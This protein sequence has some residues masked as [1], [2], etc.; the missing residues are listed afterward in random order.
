MLIL[1]AFI[2][3]ALAAPLPAPEA[4]DAT[5][6]MGP[7]LFAAEVPLSTAASKALSKRDHAAAVTALKGIDPTAFTGPQSS[8]LG[9]LKA[10]SL[11]RSNRA[12]EAQT[13]LGH[14]EASTTVPDGYRWLTIG[15]V[16]L[17]NGAL[18]KAAESFQRITP[19]EPI[20]DRAKL[21]LAA[22]HKKS[23][24]TK[25]ALELYAELAQR[26]D[27][28]D[29]G[30]IALWALASKRGLS[31]PS[32]VP[33]LRRLWVHYPLSSA[34]KSADSALKAHHG[35][36]RTEDY[37][38]RAVRLM[39][40]GAWSAVNGTVSPRIAQFPLTTTQGCEVQYAHG[41]SLFKRNQV[42]AASSV[43]SAVGK[44]CAT[45]A[46]EVGPKALY[47]AG[48][49]FERKKHWAQA[50]SVYQLIP[51]LYPE[52]SMAD[53][54]YALGGIA[55]V[56]AGQPAQA[57]GLWTKQA[58]TYPTGD[59]AGEGFWRLAWSAY[60]SGDTSKAIDWAERMER[61]VPLNVD[62]TH[63]MGARYW[64]ARWHLYPDV[65]HPE[66]LSPDA[67]AVTSGIDG[68]VSLIT[69]HPAGF[70]SLLAAARL[71][72]L[73]PESLAAIP[74]PS[75]ASAGETWTVRKTFFEH[76][77]TQRALNLAR[78]GLPQEAM[79]EFRTLGKN[80]TPS[81]IAIITQVQ[82]SYDPYVA[83]DRLH[84][85]LLHHPP[86][87]LG[88]DRDRVMLEAL[89]NHYF[90]TIELVTENYDF[91]PRIF[92]A[93]VREESSFNKDIRSWAGARGL[94]QLMPATGKQVAGWLGISVTK[95]KLHDPETNLK[96]GS[97]YL[98]YLFDHFDNNP[99][100]AVA[101]Y[102]AGEGNVGKW[103][104]RFGNIPT[105]EF[106][107]HIPFRE[108]RHYVKRVLGTYQAYRVI[109]GPDTH[110]PQWD[111]TN[112]R[113]VDP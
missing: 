57:R 2:N 1:A 88:P 22:A 28:A 35:T 4:N 108:T 27:P 17:A 49:S 93:L 102:N 44:K 36:I 73:A 39:E 76:P 41:R 37:A 47:I 40:L 69:D 14:I 19:D 45:L 82:A 113:V 24:A 110:P 81:E 6:L 58:D 95:S 107:E 50:A 20:A 64:S 75:A 10:W 74:A 48:K 33:W 18:H 31:N 96:I 51:V 84:R 92:H 89:P 26:D 104:K 111:H 83:H 71:A 72:E 32:A 61:E 65:Q 99:F 46:P 8:A 7:A 59:M 55:W 38:D 9:F 21:Q 70:Y 29:S 78:L 11:I 103:V 90:D 100:L 62:P 91:D 68:L 23:G 43:L 109:R 3:A 25:K 54:G 63:V 87:S 94:S 34:A 13:L 60:Q 52:H 98:H 30:E 67:E 5:I 77:A 12:T 15:E 106:I 53:D 112:H 16:H 85:A 56:E 97:R 42:T 66:L 86:S 79:S 105:D 80:L 101:G